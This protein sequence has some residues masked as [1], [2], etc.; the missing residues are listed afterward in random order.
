MTFIRN[1]G[2]GLVLRHAT[3]G[4]ADQ[5]AAFNAQMHMERDATEP[6]K[7]VAL[8]TRDLMAGTHPT[9][10]ASNFLVVKK[11]VDECSEFAPT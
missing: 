1:L 9:T 5:V 3:P 10:K 8:W 2:D 11:S 6:D 4:D 7:L